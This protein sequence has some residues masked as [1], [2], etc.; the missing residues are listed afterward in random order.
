MLPGV[1][2]YNFLIFR[3][4]ISQVFELKSK[5]QKMDSELDMND[6]EVYSEY[7]ESLRNGS[8]GKMEMSPPNSESYSTQGKL[9]PT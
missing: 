8:M 9:L 3:Q 5:H 6:E 2:D 4:G 7:G 1:I